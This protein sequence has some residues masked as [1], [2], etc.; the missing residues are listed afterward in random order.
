MNR[1]SEWAKAEI[2]DGASIKARLHRALGA[3]EGTIDEELLGVVEALVHCKCWSSAD[4]VL[5]RLGY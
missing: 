4:T 3:K 5:C 2:E 1:Y